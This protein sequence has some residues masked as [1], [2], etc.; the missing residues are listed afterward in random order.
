MMY[1]YLN[2]HFQGQKVN[3]ILSPMRTCIQWYRS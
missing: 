3:S 2:V 1:C